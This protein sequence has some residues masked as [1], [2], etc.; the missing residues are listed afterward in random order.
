MDI[1][2]VLKHDNNSRTFNGKVIIYYMEKHKKLIKNSG[3][4]TQSS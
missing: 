2:F 3:F 1:S 4:N